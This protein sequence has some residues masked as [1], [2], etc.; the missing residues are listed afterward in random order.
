MNRTQF[1]LVIREPIFVGIR[2]FRSLR[3]DESIYAFALML[4]QRGNYLGFAV[5]TEEGL[6]RV[7]AQYVTRGYGKNT[8]TQTNLP[9]ESHARIG[10]NAVQI[11]RRSTS[12]GRIHA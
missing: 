8:G 7:A 10:P 5:A 2:D 1:A 9:R 4:G 3:P 12:R 6:C 11:E